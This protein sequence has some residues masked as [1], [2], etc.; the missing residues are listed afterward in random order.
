MAVRFGA[1]GV[2]IER[3][4]VAAYTIPTDSPESD[5]TLEWDETTIVVVEATGGGARG[6]GYSYA[7][8]AT[9]RL[10]RDLLAGVVRGRD[11]LA[12][13]AAWD[14]MARAVR[15]LGR[16]GVASTAIA[17]VD[18][19]L[20]DLKARLLGL[21]LAALLGAARSEVAAYGR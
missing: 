2:P 15:N 7:D 21:P 4:E 16:P 14:A 17:A 10:I 9:A 5:G 19:A 12:V 11:A 8:A 3:V 18:T 6:L 1:G 13:P 20:W